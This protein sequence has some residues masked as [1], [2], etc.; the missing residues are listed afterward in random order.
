MGLYVGRELAALQAI[1]VKRLR[2]RHA[3]VYG[4]TTNAA[5]KTWLVKRVLWR[6]CH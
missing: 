6:M 2:L 5:N 1:T 3:E 4:E